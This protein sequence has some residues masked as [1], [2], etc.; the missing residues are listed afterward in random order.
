MERCG[1]VD[2]SQKN[3]EVIKQLVTNSVA[4]IFLNRADIGKLDKICLEFSCGSY[5]FGN[6]C[7]KAPA[8]VKVCKSI[9]IY[10]SVLEVK[11]E[12][13][14]YKNKSDNKNRRITV[15]EL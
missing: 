6:V 15:Y 14:L 5:P 3:T 4:V 10:L 12:Q 9:G 8:V 7:I 11:E 2:L 13:K 1:R